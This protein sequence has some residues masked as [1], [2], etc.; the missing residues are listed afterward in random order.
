ML[1]WKDKKL[2]DLDLK[3]VEK[4]WAT[5]FVLLLALG[6]MAFFG[7][8]DPSANN[9]ATNLTGAAAKVD[10][11]DIS[12]TEFRR[13]YQNAHSEYQK[14]YK[15]NFD[16][17]AMQLSKMVLNSLVSEHILHKEAEKAGFYTSDQEIDSFL[18]K[19]QIFKDEKGNFSGELLDNY[20]R[21]NGYTEAS[22]TETVRRQLT[23]N[24]FRSLLMEA[25]YTPLDEVK[26][27]YILRETRY[28]VR[29]IKLDKDS[30]KVTVPEAEVQAF[31]T[32]DG[33]AKIAQY[34]EAN[35]NSFQ[36]DK[37]VQ[38]QHIL[39]AFQESRNASGA[40]KERTKEAARKLADELLAQ[41][42]AKKDQFAALASKHS[43]DIS[44]KEK[45]GDLGFFTKDAMVPEFSNVA[46]NLQEG[47]VSDVVESP[48]GFH[49]IKVNKVQPA[50]TTT[51][52]EATPQ[53]AQTL[54]SKDR[55]PK[56]IEELGTTLLNEVKSGN[57]PRA[58]ALLAAN[59]LKWEETGEFALTSRF[60]PKI[61]GDNAVK[62][63]IFGLKTPGQTADKVIDVNGSKF[64]VQLKAI[65]AADLTALNDKKLDELRKTEKMMAAYS[66]AGEL[67]T[68]VEQKYRD[69]GKVW[70][71]AE[72]RDFD[73]KRAAS[74][75]TAEE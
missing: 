40:A 37:K 31:I 30:L 3:K 57:T 38:A 33:K 43:D 75:Q 24:K 56:L 71:N 48:F 27:N 67:T 41:A 7:V 54:L 10:G 18:T 15:D 47:A 74:N 46:F 22:F 26:S 69:N 28:D 52:E 11:T 35:K 16:P 2:D 73:A 61:G 62:D 51:L 4:N 29:F 12:S 66:L 34:Y 13:A 65:K 5:Y 53:I 44:T 8:C 50:K 64:I 6:A 70:E 1:R 59:N 68:L 60:I 39:I 14:R 20:M 19:V 42:K 23:S 63:A 25:Q 32:G 58:D 72:F 9:I 36:S 55:R 17:A 21:A 49:I 45:G